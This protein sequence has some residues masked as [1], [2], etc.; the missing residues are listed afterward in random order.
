MCTNVHCLFRKLNRSLCGKTQQIQINKWVIKKRLSLWYS[1]RCLSLSV[2]NN[3]ARENC[4]RDDRHLSTLRGFSS[5][6]KIRQSLFQNLLLSIEINVE[7]GS[8][9]INRFSVLPIVMAE[10][11]KQVEHIFVRLGSKYFI[12]WWSYGKIK[13]EDS[14]AFAAIFF[15]RPRSDKTRTFKSKRKP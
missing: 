1:L 10:K 14:E 15:Q 4:V 6:L 12:E 13:V 9:S 5:V 7:K 3:F 2:W 8:F 11:S